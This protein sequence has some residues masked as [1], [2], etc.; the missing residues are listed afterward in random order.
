V[1]NVIV[2]LVGVALGWGLSE[3]SRFVHERDTRRNVRVMLS[4]EVD[5]N[6]SAL[7][8]YWQM[9][10]GE[11]RKEGYTGKSLLDASSPQLVTL[12]LPPWSGVRWEGLSAVLPGAVEKGKLKR[13]HRFY[14]QLGA[15]SQWHA[16]LVALDGEER[17][18][19]LRDLGAWSTRF[20]ESRFEQWTRF[21]Q[22]VEQTL[23]TGNPLSRDGKMGQLWLPEDEE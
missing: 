20:A 3:A 22:V 11:A 13:V 19:M 17:A 12:R 1:N 8:E 23:A 18:L 7:R 4:L 6:L 10:T 21:Q 16:D 5:D 15:V 2:A 9:L 14:R